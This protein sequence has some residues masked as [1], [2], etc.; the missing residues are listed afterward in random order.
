MISHSTLLE[1]GQQELKKVNCLSLHVSIRAYDNTTVESVDTRATS[2]FS[3]VLLSVD[4]HFKVA[5]VV[6]VTTLQ[7][8]VNTRT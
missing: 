6:Q 2:T 5:R 3:I 1:Q 8:L 7:E 4:E